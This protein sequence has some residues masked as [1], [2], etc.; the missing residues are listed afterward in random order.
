M[1]QNGPA[2]DE[3]E[4]ERVTLRD[5]SE[6]DKILYGSRKV[7]CTVTTADPVGEDDVTTSSYVGEFK[8]ETPRGKTRRLSIASTSGR[9]PRNETDK[10]YEATR[11][12]SPTWV[13]YFDD[14]YRVIEDG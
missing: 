8:V 6:G 3:Y 2:D 11:P 7:P 5:L 9:N 13:N 12:D 4:T 1:S 10:R 14:L